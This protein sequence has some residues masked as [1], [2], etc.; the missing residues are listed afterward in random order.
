MIEEAVAT[1]S[2]NDAAPAEALWPS[3]QA[4]VERSHMRSLVLGTS[5]DPNAKITILLLP[6]GADRP[7]L[8]VKVPTTDA[9][10]RAVDREGRMLVELRRRCG[11]RLLRTI[12]RV[13]DLLEFNGRHALVVTA[14]PGVPMS[15]TYLRWRH[16]AR[17][18]AVA[19]DFAI[20]GGWIAALQSETARD[21][22]PL[23]MGKD[24]AGILADRY[25][26]EPRIG[27]SIA[28]L[29]S[30]RE[31]LR[32]DRTPRA[33]VHGDFWFGNLLTDSGRVTGVVDWELGIVSDEP[34]RDL[35]RFPLMYALY[36]DRQATPGLSVAGHHGLRRSSWGAGV[37]HAIDGSGWFPDLVRG[38][39]QA[40]LHRLG[41]S[42]EAW[43]DA[44][45]AGIAEVAAT[46]DDPEF[47]RLHLGLFQ[48]IAG[49][50][51][52]NGKERS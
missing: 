26:D 29:E 11:R 48:R 46:T 52:P 9:A 34:V 8:A 7:V 22:E 19:A 47:G 32:T 2:R 51:A 27:P 50:S 10:A 24:M 25:A 49:S 44:A 12:P 5:K 38:F 1:E 39:I 15:A 14:V 23:D 13:V 31:R 6:P 17:R 21:P 30:I 37:A 18:R 28:R 16:T 33:A 20:A 45:L 41:A 43:R 40:G 3:L 35:V 36:L 42:P 4:F